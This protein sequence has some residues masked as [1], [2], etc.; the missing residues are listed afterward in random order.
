MAL[1]I[2]LPIKAERLVLDEH[3]FHRKLY[4]PVVYGAEIHPHCGESRYGWN[5]HRLEEVVGV[6][7]I[8]V[9]TNRQAVPVEFQVETGVQ[10]FGGLP[11]EVGIREVR[12]YYTLHNGAGVTGAV[13]RISHAGIIGKCLVR[14]H[15]LI[16]Y[17][18]PT[19]TELEH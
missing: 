3:R 8:Y 19:G 17:A 2:V 15:C 9:Q 12:G 10:L 7:V 14:R 6:L 4:A 11:F 5:A 16:T 1:P 18:S 13:V